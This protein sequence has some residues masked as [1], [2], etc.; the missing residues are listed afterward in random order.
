MPRMANGLL[1]IVALAGPT[2]AGQSDPAADAFPASTASSNTPTTAPIESLSPPLSDPWAGPAI[3]P[4]LPP[5]PLARQNG[6]ADSAS[7]ATVQPPRAGWLRSTL[8]LGLVIGLILLLGWGYRV[9]TGAGGAAALLRGRHAGLVEVITRVPLR[10]RQALLLVRVGPRLVLVGT[11]AESIRTLHTIEDE[12]L[13]ARLLGQAAR[14]QPGSS[15]AEFAQVLQQAEQTPVEPDP[16]ASASAGH[17]AARTGPARPVRPP[18][19]APPP[20][21]RRFADVKAKLLE[22]IQRLGT[23]STAQA[24]PRPPADPDTAP[25]TRSQTWAA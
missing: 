8:A 13:C 10:P 21:Q 5:R 15:T 16:T 12:V 9:T 24:T 7:G 1:L 14:G 20:D 23:A 3:A 4:D 11:S 17:P 19:L 25:P 6:H 2:L 18:A 22:T